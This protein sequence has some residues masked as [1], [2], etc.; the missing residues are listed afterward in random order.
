MI[1]LSQ[2]TRWH[3]PQ[4]GQGIW[5]RAMAL[6]V[7]AGIV[8]AA[9][10]RWMDHVTNFGHQPGMPDHLEDPATDSTATAITAPYMGRR[11]LHGPISRDPGPVCGKQAGPRFSLQYGA[12]EL[13]SAIRGDGLQT[14]DAAPCTEAR[15]I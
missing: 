13:I 6:G 10:V 3:L 9:L 2:K 11:G 1:I 7:L 4:P 14:A 8:V 15:H 5:L 12:E